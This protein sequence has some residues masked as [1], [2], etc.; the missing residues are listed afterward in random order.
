MTDALDRIEARTPK[1]RAIYERSSEVLAQE[2]V[3]TVTM[4]YPV[5]IESA[6][7]SQ[8][9][10]VDGNEYIDLVGGF[11][12]H[13]LG[14]APDVVVEALQKAVTGGVQFGLHNPYQ[15]PLARLIVDAVACAE[16]VM[17][18]NSGTEA[19]MYAIRAARA[20]SGR[21]KIA[22]FEGGF[23][24]A[25]D[26]VMGKV[27]TSSPVDAPTSYPMGDGIPA[28]TRS[29]MMMLPYMNDAAFDLIREH[30]NE[31]ALV[32]IEPVQGSHP[33]LDAGEF[34]G[35]L[36]E[37]CR[38]AGVLIL[39]DEVITGF[40]LAFGGAQEFFGATPD[41]AIYGKAPGGGMPLGVIA[42]RGDIM[43]VFT[44]QF[45]I[46]DDAGAGG[47]SI[48]TAGTFSGNPMTMAAG[49]AAIT[50]M[51]DNPDMYRHI[52]EM[53]ARLADGVNSFCQAEEIPALMSSALSM[54]FFRMQ[55]GGKI[56]SVRDIDGSL[57]KADDMFLANLLERGVVM[58]PMHIGYIG[59]THTPEDIDA[60]VAAIT[61]SLAE[62]RSAGLI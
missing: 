45:D 14:H 29:T 18:C 15:E 52:A 62:V 5:Y 58:A 51:R 9:T 40:R 55:P 41:M 16:K 49:T 28:E 36:V 54:F 38:E 60:A 21:T 23:H 4:P 30:K 50:Y 26:Y 8:L 25:H 47:A 56:D 1:S 20:F 35:K 31:L 27:D 13:V 61:E 37:V 39:F 32:M 48:F 7:G 19:S 10:D 22:M 24:G 33:R 57:K 34:L 43:S 11:G 44:R 3:D 6:K 12:P 46:Y 59:A 42:G 2:I 53:G 17:F